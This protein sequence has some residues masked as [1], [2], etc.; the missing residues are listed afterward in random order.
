MMQEGALTS[1][2]LCDLYRINTD[3]RSHVEY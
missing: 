1:D 2:A 3:I